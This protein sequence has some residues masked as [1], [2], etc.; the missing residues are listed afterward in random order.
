MKLLQI[1]EPGQ[2][3]APHEDTVAVGIDLG[4]THSV[5]AIWHEGCP[6]AIETHI[7]SSIIPSVVSYRADGAVI[8]GEVARNEFLQGAPDAVASI[9]RLMGRSAQEAARLMPHLSKRIETC[10]EDSVP[11]IITCAGAKTPVEI[12]ADI[13]KHLRVVAETALGKE[14]R[15][16]VITVPA[17]FDEAARIATK[18]AA[19]LAGLDVL[20]LI[21]EPTAA[22]LAYG[23]DTKAEGIY[24][25]YDLGGGTFDVSLLK[26]EGGVFQV[27]ATAGDTA[28]GGDDVD[29]MIADAFLDSC[30]AQGCEEI[31]SCGASL[32]ALL[33]KA[34]AAKEALSEQ[35]SIT[36]EPESPNQQPF[37]LNRTQLAK[38]AMPLIERTI[39]ICSQA[40]EDA[41]LASAEVKGVVMVGGSTRLLAVREAVEDFFGK[42]LLLDIDP[43]RV[44]AYGAA[45]QAHQ[46]TSGEGDHLLLDVV[47][48]SLGLETMGDLAEKLIYRNTPIPVSVSQEFTTYEAGQTGMQIHVVQGERELASQCRSLARFELTGI[49]PMAPGAAR[50]SISFQVD[51][52]GLLTVSAEETTTGQR[53]QVVVKPS[54]GLPFDEIERM[55]RESMEHARQ[56]ITARLLTES[57]VEAQRLL[58]D[59]ALAMKADAAVLSEK[60]V[61][62]IR[63]AA[64]ELESALSGDDRDMIDA[65]Q[66][67]LQHAVAPFAQKRMDKAIGQALKGSHIEDI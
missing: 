47:P 48:L 20:R 8:V 22:A 30:K 34:R 32:A 21:N 13:L 23:L 1:H 37:T 4:T 60:E 57:K 12:S 51:A 5:V 9:K 16:A 7:G 18:D 64:T 46:L 42:K 53:Q 40:L 35:E 65:A 11:R 36:L 15:E 61:T 50:I 44:V 59:V 3:P 39:S 19:R 58:N 63:G 38:L 17:Y 52:D 62:T 45:I 55:L 14:V 41:G 33:G 27:L 67:A 6:V 66:M 56:D 25:V 2:T 28:L 54:Y 24:A 43:D 49:P 29:R 26:L 10:A 31:L